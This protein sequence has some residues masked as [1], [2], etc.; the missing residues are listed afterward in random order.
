MSAIPPPLNN[1]ADAETEK[2]IAA[3][4]RRVAI[5]HVLSTTGI[6]V[7][8]NLSMP[9]LLQKVIDAGME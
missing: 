2:A 6:L 9:Q 3:L 7:C 5:N 8:D 4:V 1:Q